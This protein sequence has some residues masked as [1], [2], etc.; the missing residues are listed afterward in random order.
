M[1]ILASSSNEI[2]ESLLRHGYAVVEHPRLDVGRYAEALADARAFFELPLDVKQGL[3]IGTS[4]HYR[5]YS[6]MR[7]ERDWRQQIHFGR[8]REA[9]SDGPTYRGLLG[10]NLWP[11]DPAWRGRLLRLLEDLDLIGREVLASIARSLS[12]PPDAFLKEDEE[13]YLL[14]KLIDYHPAPAAGARSGV[15]PHVDFSWIT[16]VLEDR[17]GG[18]EIQRPDGAWMDAPSVPGTLLVHVGEILQYATGGRMRV[19]P[20][21]VANRSPDH[22]RVSIPFFLNPGLDTV[23]RR[24]ASA[25]SRPTRTEAGHTH[26]VLADDEPGSFVFGEAEWRRKALGRWCATCTGPALRAY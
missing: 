15:A 9:V 2:S 10:P 14:L 11:K 25:S 17:T 24:G 21:R 19:T 20:H 5:G 18:L 12:L 13:P 22:S 4:P 23:I 16:L 7:S 26:H 3:A 1:R 6:E 8:E